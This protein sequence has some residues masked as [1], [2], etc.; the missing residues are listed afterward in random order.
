MDEPC[1]SRSCI[2]RNETYPGSFPVTTNQARWSCCPGC[3]DYCC[4][5]VCSEIHRKRKTF[6]YRL[7]AYRCYFGRGAVVSFPTAV[8]ATVIRRPIMVSMTIRFVMFVI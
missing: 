8:P 2:E 5:V 3:R 1:E 6:L 4:R 7:P